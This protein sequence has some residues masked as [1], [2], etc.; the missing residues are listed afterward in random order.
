MR[1]YIVLCSLLFVFP[2]VYGSETTTT[3]KQCGGV[4]FKVTELRTDAYRFQY[5]LSALRQD[6][7]DEVEIYAHNFN[8]LFYAACIT[9]ADK[10]QYILI[11]VFYLSEDNDPPACNADPYY[12]YGIV[13]PSTL[14]LPQV[15]SLGNCASDRFAYDKLGVS[16]EYLPSSKDMFCCERKEN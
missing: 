12:R 1:R 7:N 8:G 16:I 13:D 11:Q 2:P 9:A 14:S 10:K 4:T 6:S 5:S 15:P 3:L